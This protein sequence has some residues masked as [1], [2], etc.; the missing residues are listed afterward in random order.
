MSAA[1]S[2]VASATGAC[3]KS[4]LA[5]SLRSSGGVAKDSAVADKSGVFLNPF[6]EINAGL[7]FL[8]LPVPGLPL[9][10][11]AQSVRMAGADD[12]LINKG[13]GQTG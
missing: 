7:S 1:V 2:A 4:S 8:S 10:N 6:I 11:D 12:H 9:A 13:L 5:C 3:P